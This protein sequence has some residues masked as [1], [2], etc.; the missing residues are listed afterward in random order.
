MTAIDWRELADVVEIADG[1]ARTR[2]YFTDGTYAEEAIGLAVDRRAQDMLGVDVVLGR[3]FVDED[4]VDNAENVVLIG[5]TLW[6]TRFAAA[7]D[8]IGQTVRASLDDQA[9]EG[10]AFRVVGVLRPNFTYAADMARDI[11]IAIPQRGT[12]RV[13]FVRLREGIPAPFAERRITEAA[14]RVAGATSADW[15]VR[16][17]SV[18]E[19]YVGGL[20]PLL[21]A[22]AGAAGLM[23]VIVCSNVVVLMLLRSSRRRRE[24]AVHVALGA[25]PSAVLRA[26]AAE[27]VLVMTAAV[28]FGLA[29][30]TL[31]LRFLEPSIEQHLGRPA[32]G[33]ATAIDLSY[34]VTLAIAGIGALA[35]LVLCVV[36]A[37]AAWPLQLSGALRHDSRSGIS[38]RSSRHVRSALIGFEVASSVAMLAA[39]GLMVR[40]AVNLVGTDLGFRTEGVVRARL[41]LP[42]H[43][44]P[45]AEAL[46]GYHERF[47][48]LVSSRGS[49]PIAVTNFPPFY[50][51]PRQA[52]LI[53]ESDTPRG[54]AGVTAVSRDYFSVLDI[55]IAAG[56]AFTSSDRVGAEAVAVV[57]VSLARELWPGGS[58]VGKRLRTAEQPVANAPLGAWRTVVGVVEDVRQ[59]H[60]DAE[61]GDVYLP[62]LQAPNQYAP[63]FI[64]TDRPVEE[65]VAI[66]RTAAS[67]LDRSAL[68][69][70]VT[71]I[72]AEGDRLLAP[73]R[74]VASILTAFAA[75]ASVIAVVGIYAV[76]AYAVHQRTRESAI[77]IAVGA[78]HGAIVRMFLKEGGIV[79]AVG[80]A[81]GALG[82]LGIARLLATQLYDVA[83]FD[84]ATLAA[85]CAALSAAALVAMWVAARAGAASNPLLSLTEN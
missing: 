85:A 63:L 69:S 68:I 84:P 43:N 2:F 56:R 76:T 9:D 51:P 34:G 28:V 31:A 80:T 48:D 53:D 12:P 40:T 58:A 47:L 16:L 32:P 17:E 62:F 44:Y 74:F 7:P 64:R 26:S 22:V 24:V 25:P 82:A 35:A 72:E 11:A 36:P 38:G 3:R 19:R 66:L 73:A 13:Y 33:G 78:T 18:R 27:S 45:S 6:R 70:G 79:L 59:H 15:S 75:F 30:A 10:Q 37:F 14:R 50:A 1:T 23:F 55:P 5:N 46:V 52:V 29:L 77:R 8:V 39:C 20:R 71:S 49:A 67:E 4:F 21:F 57:S 65:W 42:Q 61:V 41:A 60:T 81:A 83:P 54:R